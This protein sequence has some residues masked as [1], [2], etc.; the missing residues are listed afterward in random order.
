M[1]KYLE[2]FN[3]ICLNN[4]K[5]AEKPGEG[6]YYKLEYRTGKKRGIYKCARCKN[7]LYSSDHVFDSTTGWPAFFDTIDGYTKS[8]VVFHNKDTR[9]LRCMK[10]GVHLGHRLKK[11]KSNKNPTGIH[12]CLNSACLFFVETQRG[13][14]K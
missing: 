14:K 2:V 3:R 7:N 12:D 10:C 13:G 1:Q 6:E 5:D 4:E 8:E 9:E 11:K